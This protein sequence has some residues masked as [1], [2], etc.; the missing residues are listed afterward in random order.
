MSS[1]EFLSRLLLT[2]RLVSINLVQ[3]LITLL[4]FRLSQQFYEQALPMNFILAIPISLFIA[5]WLPMYMSMR[6]FHEL[7][8]SI[9]IT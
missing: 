7:N 1:V 5:P 6:N 9:K 4:K 3:N 2:I 8:Q